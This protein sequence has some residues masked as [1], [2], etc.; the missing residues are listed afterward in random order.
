MHVFLQF[1]LSWVKMEISGESVDVRRTSSKLFTMRL[2]SDSKSTLKSP[3][4]YTG[5]LGS[6]SNY[7]SSMLLSWGAPWEKNFM[8]Y[9]KI[10]DYS[11]Y[12]GWFY[13]HGFRANHFTVD[14]NSLDDFE[15]IYEVNK[16]LESQ[17]SVQKG[18]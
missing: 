10:A 16:Y 3:M 17:Y 8:D 2:F 12:A 4:M 18:E 1:G 9:Q 11:E 7:D 15:D 13:L 6:C 5:C 14:V